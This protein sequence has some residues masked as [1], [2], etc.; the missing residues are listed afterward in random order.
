MSSKTHENTRGVSIIEFVQVD[1]DCPIYLTATKCPFKEK[2]YDLHNKHDVPYMLT[3]GKL[4]Y[5]KN[6]ANQNQ[7][8]SINLEETKRQICKKCI[9]NV[10]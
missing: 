8:F 6:F 9:E 10:R 4:Y 1:A 7:D 3:R 2:L 5:P